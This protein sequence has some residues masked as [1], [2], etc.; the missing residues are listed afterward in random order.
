MAYCLL[1]CRLAVRVIVGQVSL[2]GLREERGVRVRGETD[3][4][5]LPLLFLFE[6]K[7]RKGF[8]NLG[9]SVVV[10]FFFLVDRLT[11]SRSTHPLL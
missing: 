9:L 6:E 3:I 4:P 7:E 10:S 11:H 2:M 8:T 1:F 5:S